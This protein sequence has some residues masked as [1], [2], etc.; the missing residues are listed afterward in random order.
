MQEN[1]AEIG[2]PRV[3][4]DTPITKEL[5]QKYSHGALIIYKGMFLLYLRD[6]KE[7][8]ADRNKLSIIGGG[9]EKEE[10]VA[11]T[12]NREANEELGINLQESQYLGILPPITTHVR[13]ISVANI[14]DEEFMNIKFGN[15]G[16]FWGLYDLEWLLSHRDSLASGL[17]TIFA[18][19]NR[20]SLLKITQGRF[21]EVIPEALG[22]INIV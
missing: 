7:G 8:L 5:P 16:Q 11:E 20:E 10:T 14:N 22:L 9:G 18:N 17:S 3:I 19:E 2:L 6:D 4:F 13:H 12:L 15:E 21:R 1:L